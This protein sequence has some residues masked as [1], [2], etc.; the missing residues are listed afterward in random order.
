MCDRTMLTWSHTDQFATFNVFGRIDVWSTWNLSHTHINWIKNETI[1]TFFSLESFEPNLIVSVKF[2]V[3][4]I[5]LSI[6]NPNHIIVNNKY[7]HDNIQNYLRRLSIPILRIESNV[8]THKPHCELCEKSS[9]T[10]CNFCKFND[11]HYD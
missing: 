1:V 9:I 6:S 11:V 3:G 10:T 8:N 4:K 5:F 2:V 7:V